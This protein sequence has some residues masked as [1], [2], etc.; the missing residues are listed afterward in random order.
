MFNIRRMEPE[1]IEPVAAIEAATFS[2]PWSVNG[3]KSALER[4]DTIFYVAYDEDKIL[5]Y[6][7]FYYGIDEAD[8]TNVAVAEGARGQG[9]GEMLIANVLMTCSMKGIGM[10]G[11]EVR[12]GNAPAIALYHKLGFEQVG[13]R[14]DFYS[15]PTED[16]LVMT[17]YF[18]T[19]DK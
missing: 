1:D 6:V 7:G 17:K 9:I 12:A 13:I 2:E 14:K 8:I 16:A 5:G 15:K 19:E 10:I 11:L 3:F 18:E 4:R